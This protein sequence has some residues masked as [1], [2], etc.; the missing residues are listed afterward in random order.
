MENK[1]V[2]MTDQELSLGL[3][4]LALLVTNSQRNVKETG[5]QFCLDKSQK[6][7]FGVVDSLAVAAEKTDGVVYTD[8]CRMQRGGRMKEDQKKTSA[9]KEERTCCSRIVEDKGKRKTVSF[10]VCLY[11]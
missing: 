2:H 8:E 6:E 4:Q 9:E 7:R 5:Q 3:A 1:E 10:C 11:M